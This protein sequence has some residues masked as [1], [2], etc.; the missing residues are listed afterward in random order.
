MK[1]VLLLLGLLP[2]SFL[3]AQDCSDLFISEYLEGLGNNKALEIYNPTD[4]T[5]DLSNYFVVRYNNGNM[6]P[7]LQSAVQ[8]TGTIAPHGVH[9]GVLDKRDP[10]GEGQEAPVWDDLQAKADAFYS[11]IYDE[12]NTFYW[13]GNDGVVLFKGK[14]DATLPLG[15][16]VSSL[17]NVQILDVFGKLGEDP[18]ADGW[19]YDDG[20]AVGADGI[21]MSTKDHFLIRKP[22]VKKGVTANP[23]T[24]IPKME[25]DTLSFFVY[26][27]DEN[28]D[29]VLNNQGQPAR[30]INVDS[31]GTHTCACNTTTAVNELN[32]ESFDFNVYP[33]P[34]ENKQLTL[35]TTSKAIKEITIY[36]S[37]GQ[38]VKHISN[39]NSIM[40]ISLDV[41][42]GV[43]FITAK[44]PTGLK[45]TKKFIVR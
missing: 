35:M 34:I 17:T 32:S 20:A 29:T 7:T 25:W 10:A 21:G 5:I 41:N 45:M 14:I 12:N 19:K 13:N 1:R 6:S 26:V 42:A 24:F 22:A 43:Y 9:V 18:G 39:G 2:V 8:L 30:R 3:G 15:A 31:L 40:N 28:G 11:P 37:L 16:A 4:Q 33:N 38:V 36:N 44:S 23:Q 27:L